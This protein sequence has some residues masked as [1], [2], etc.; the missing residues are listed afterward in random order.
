MSL[1]ALLQLQKQSKMLQLLSYFEVKSRPYA[2]DLLCIHRPRP[3]CVKWLLAV[4]R[5]ELKR[6]GCT[7]ITIINVDI[8]ARPAII[9]SLELHAKVANENSL[10]IM[11]NQLWKRRAY[12][13]SF[14]HLKNSFR[15]TIYNSY[16]INYLLYWKFT[17]SKNPIL[18]LPVINY[19]F[20]LLSAFSGN[21]HWN[22]LISNRKKNL[23]GESQFNW[24]GLDAKIKLSAVRKI[25]SDF[26]CFECKCDLKKIL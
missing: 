4:Q 8:A 16:S 15:G 3:R 18:V 9:V 24:V 7:H 22:K 21:T 1:K 6:K 17:T 5:G 19:C 11:C 14:L 23:W 10:I 13:S 20:K 12:S 26:K 25:H 2:I